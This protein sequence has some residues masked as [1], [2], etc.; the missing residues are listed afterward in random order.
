[1]RKRPS[2]GGGAPTVHK[3]GG[4]SLRDADALRHAL[5]IVQR[6]PRPAVVVVSAL[7]GVTDAL[8]GLAADLQ[9]GKDRLVRQTARTLQARYE[10]SARA[11]TRSGGARRALLELIGRTFDDL[12]A[13][14]GAPRLMREL[15]P[16][17]IDQLVASGEELAARIFSAG[18]V[19][20]GVASQ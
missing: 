2:G 20:L 12:R 11:V 4:A 13:L 10:E 6:G 1:M 16:R 3:F 7:A 8:I 5:S 17:S 19:G 18:L 9:N 14:A 15:S